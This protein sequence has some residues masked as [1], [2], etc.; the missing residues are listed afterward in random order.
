[1]LEAQILA[2]TAPVVQPLGPEG[3]GPAPV[4]VTPIRLDV[5][6]DADHCSVAIEGQLLAL[7]PLAAK[8]LGMVAENA[9]QVVHRW[10]LVDHLGRGTNLAQ[11]FSVVRSAFLTAVEQGT[12]SLASIR[13]HVRQ[14]NAATQV[15]ELD[16][17]DPRSV[18]RHFVAARRGHGYRI[19][20]SADE[21]TV[22]RL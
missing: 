7:P 14:H 22:R 16:A 8:A 4:G 21:V 1:M 15:A 2:A 10:D 13:A 19:C 9:G 20:L 12:I 11:V 18:L 17:L 5:T 6:W 3:G